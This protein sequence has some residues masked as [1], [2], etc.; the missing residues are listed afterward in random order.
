MFLKDSQ[1][2]LKYFQ[3]NSSI[4]KN[5]FYFERKIQKSREYYIFCIFGN[6]FLV[7]N[8]IISSDEL[9]STDPSLAKTR[10]ASLKYFAIITVQD[11]HVSLKHLI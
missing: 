6:Y 5:L 9:K 3:Y 2:C 7:Q 4:K 8:D 11:V 1:V 10:Y